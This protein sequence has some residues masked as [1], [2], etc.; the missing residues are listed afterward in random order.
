MRIIADILSQAQRPTKKMH[1][2]HKCNL[3]FKQLIQYL[4]L[5]KKRGLIRGKTGTGTIIYQTTSNGE[6]FLRRYSS[7]ARLLRL[8]T[9]KRP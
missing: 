2:M 7:L 6:E 5:L 9:L 8:P 4:N 1:I 3:S